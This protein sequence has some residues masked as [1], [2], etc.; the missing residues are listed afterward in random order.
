MSEQLP[1][2]TVVTPSYNQAQFLEQTI[3]SVIGQEYPNLEYI[4]MDGGS[5]DGSVEIIKKYEQHFTYWQSEKDNGQGAAINAGFAKA[6]GDILCWLNSD[7]LFMPGTLL[8]IGRMFQ[9]ISEPTVIFGNCLHFHEN[10]AKTRGSDVELCHKILELEMV[11][12]VIQPS[13]FW[14]KSTWEKAG[15]IDEAYT[16]AFDW[17]WFIKVKRAG[18]KF[19]PIKDY[20]SLYRIHEAHKSGSGGNKRALELAQVYKTYKSEKIG[21]A[22]LKLDSLSTKHKLF[23][24]AVYASNHYNLTFIRRM[25]HMVFFSSISFEEFSQM[26]PR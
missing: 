21:N 26:A 13:S 19:V 2:I 25:I 10:S 4:L 20:L 3:L 14:T 7:D 18:V 22:F 9:N 24:N 6:T 17:D 8:K 23:H 1:K 11:D 16:F 5:K 15:I 12:Y